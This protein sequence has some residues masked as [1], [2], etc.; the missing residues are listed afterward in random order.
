MKN[1]GID[2][3]IFKDIRL[4]TIDLLF[5]LDVLPIDDR[6]HQLVQ[7]YGSL[8]NY[9]SS[10]QHS[11]LSL[12]SFFSLVT[13]NM[14]FTRLILNNVMENVMTSDIM[15]IFFSLRTNPGIIKTLD[16]YNARFTFKETKSFMSLIHKE[17]NGFVNLVLDGNY[18]SPTVV[19]DMLTKFGTNRRIQ[20]LHLVYNNIRFENFMILFSALEKNNTLIELHVIDNNLTGAIPSFISLLTRNNSLQN[21][22]FYIGDDL[23]PHDLVRQTVEVLFLI[24]N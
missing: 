8:N 17:G 11:P 23:P 21:I 12:A 24:L 19:P 7:Y 1:P 5:G 16:L 2:V 3:V 20:I 6:L 15:Q 10:F 14:N 4:E 9:E 22:D 18:F 13:K